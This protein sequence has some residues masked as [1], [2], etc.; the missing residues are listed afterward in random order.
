MG[1]PWTAQAAQTTEF[2]RANFSQCSLALLL[3]SMASA[4]RTEEAQRRY[5]PHP[6]EL[7]YLDLERRKGRSRRSEQGSFQYAI[8]SGGREGARGLRVPWDLIGTSI[9]RDSE[10]RDRVNRV[11]AS[12]RRH[13][14]IERRDCEDMSADSVRDM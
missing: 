10:G 12:F 5:S 9:M 14:P 13:S 2:P 6:H 1:F 11:C 3:R 4:S 7:P 8:R